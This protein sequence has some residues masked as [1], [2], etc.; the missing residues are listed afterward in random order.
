[1]Q[2]HEVN[3]V[4]EITSADDVADLVKAG[5]KLVAVI[6]GRRWIS[7]NEEIGPIYILGR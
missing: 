4:V 2:L 3:E 5:W 7:G 6:A 1:M